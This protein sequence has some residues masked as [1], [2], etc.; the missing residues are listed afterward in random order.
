MIERSVALASVTKGQ[1]QEYIAD[2]KKRWRMFLRSLSFSLQVLLSNLSMQG[3]VIT[4]L[5][6]TEL[7]PISKTNK[8]NR[9]EQ[10]ICCSRRLINAIYFVILSISSL[11]KSNLACEK[12][13]IQR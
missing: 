6:V 4:I 9:R 1:F 2:R 13:L 10:S 3:N 12:F 5:L 8:L 11:M 7:S